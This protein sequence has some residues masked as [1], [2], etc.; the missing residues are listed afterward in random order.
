MIWAGSSP[1]QSLYNEEYRPQFHFSPQ[2]GWIGD[3]DGL[4]K[5]ENKYH[6]FWWGHAESSD[7][8]YWDEKVYPM[9]GDDGT[10]SYY[11]GSVIVDKDNTSGFGN[12]V[13][14][15]MVAIYTA[16]NKVSGIQDQRISYS[17]DHEIFNYYSANPVLDIGSKEFRDPDVFWYTPS[18]KW[19]MTI[20]L[21]LERK[22]NF[23][24]STDLK[25][26]EYLSSFGPVG[27]REQV[28]EVP[29]LISLP[30]NDDLNNRKW[31]MLCSMGPNKMQYFPGNFDG[32]TFSLDAESEAYLIEGEGIEGH[33]FESFETGYDGWTIE[34]NAFGTAPAGGGHPDQTVVSGFLGSHLVNSYTIGDGG[35]GKL[36]SP[37]FVAEKKYINFLISGGNSAALLS[38]NLVVDGLVVKKA[39]G[40][41]SEALKWKSFDASAYVGK[42][43]HLEIV[44]T[45]TS[46]WGHLNID[47]IMFS[48]Y[49]L[50]TEREHAYW[51]DYGADF[52]AGRTFRDY[53]DK[54]S[55][56]I[57]LGWMSNWE[58]ANQ[59]PTSWGRGFESIPRTLSLVTAPENKFLRQ[60]PIADLEKLR[61]E[62]TEVSSE[63][64][65]GIR[66]V[67]EFDPSRNTYEFEATFEMADETTHFGLNLYK[68][69]AGKLT[70]GY[71]RKTS[72]VYL[73]R[74][75]AGNSSFS[76]HFPKVSHAPLRMTGTTVKFH[77][78][79]DQSSV[80]VFVN[81]GEVVLSSLVFP[82]ADSRGVEIFS[83][84]GSVMLQDLR[85]WQLASIWGIEPPGP[86]T[87]AV[88][89]TS[90]KIQVYPNPL[91][92]GD[93]IFIYM[94]E[95]VK[96]T[97]VKSVTIHDS[98]GRLIWTGKPRFDENGRV[99]LS[100]TIPSGLYFLRAYSTNK[101]F[102][103]TILVK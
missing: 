94:N 72:L 32:T 17:N 98:K 43:C 14:P 63:T 92:M 26:W 6:L 102:Q 77:V 2:G 55:A 78:Y 15:S 30:V 82:F 34:G 103:E 37:G 91:R 51:L 71:D 39:T 67:T 85:F 33:I 90:D 9:R 101:S 41:N 36:I 60:T 38:I 61:G 12:G 48:D 64:I 31:V 23:Y 28:W 87:G 11:T 68:S 70:I 46:G 5:F 16:H 3:P 65:S 8:V 79:V 24:S 45:H 1:A 20:T 22:I 59:T 95:G 75:F 53:D 13:K 100:P 69:A 83:E 62:V 56:P 10:F 88:K 35:T 42:E 4:I 86:V 29:Q 40:S 57:L 25:Q 21:P 52:Y 19:I 58:Y 7:L 81:D 84:G 99:Y 50:N 73:D 44:D 49:S 47:H 74:R 93:S 18:G 89:E 97:Q 80:E 76:T 27:A 66:P 96:N 54:T